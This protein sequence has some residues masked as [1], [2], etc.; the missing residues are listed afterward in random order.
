MTKTLKTTLLGLALAS[1][2]FG[3]LADTYTASAYTKSNPAIGYLATGATQDSAEKAAIALC[4]AT[5]PTD[6]CP[7]RYPKLLA[8]AYGGTAASTGVYFSSDAGAKKVME[9]CNDRRCRLLWTR[10]VPGFFAMYEI[11]VN[12]K[13]IDYFV[14]DGAADPKTVL[15]DAKTVCEKLHR[16]KCTLSNSG[17]FSGDADNSKPLPFVRTPFLSPTTKTSS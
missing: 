12:D 10:N 8:R 17:A 15:V 13:L 1:A 16:G 2:S 14:A 11:T 3:S 5:N 4:R 6:S 7:V 9:T